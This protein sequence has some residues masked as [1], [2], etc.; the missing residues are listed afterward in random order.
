MPLVGGP[1]A[2]LS[3]SF[4]DLVWR[5]NIVYNQCW[6]DPAVDRQALDLQP[7][8][9][10][11]VITSAGCN[12][13]DYALLGAQVL[14]VDANPRQ[15][16]LLELKRAGIA[17][18]DF[19]AFFALF[20]HGGSPLS[21]DI[22]EALRPELKDDAR[23]FWDREIH[24]FAPEARGG[25]FYYQ[26][27][28]GLVA[29]LMAFYIDHLP[30]GRRLLDRLLAAS[31]LEEQVE[32][33]ETEL[34]PRVLGERLLKAAG[35]PVVL[36]LL[37]VPGPQRQMVVNARGGVA[38]FLGR[39]FDQVMSVGLFRDNYFWSVYVNGRYTPASCPEYLKRPNFDR[40]KAG[41][42]ANVRSFTS[43]VTEYLAMDEGGFSAFVLLDH[44]DWLVQSPR[45][46][47]EEWA[48]IFAASRPGARV[49][50]RS[51]GTDARF[52]P[53]SVARRLVFDSERA[54]RLHLQDRVGTYGSFRIARLAAA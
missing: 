47:E 17:A 45:L 3:R 49:I 27:T 51:G 42:V 46:I 14:A 52:L 48:G 19:D 38:G 21:R 39:C 29:S 25:S 28:S 41:L 5:H 23:R 20:G 10:I 34:R 6:E 53:V 44:M 16:H 37:G 22:Y 9:R 40:L 15:N 18:L 35:S 7:T 32:L 13:L 43:T 26:G 33:Y 11:L 31:N 54:S 8:D 2:L 1:K 50:F 4:F 24:L 36:T 30:Q 12:A